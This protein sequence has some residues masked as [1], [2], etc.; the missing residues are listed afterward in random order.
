M[1]KREA[2]FSS[3]WDTDARRVLA[4]ATR[5]CGPDDAVEVV[6]ETFLH[7]WRT[8]DSVPTPALPW[9]ICT[10]RNVIRNVRRGQ[11][12]HLSASPI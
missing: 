2:S 4:Y 1:T 12:R 8:W 3:C 7:A 9:L 6:S 11:R 5:H 10:A